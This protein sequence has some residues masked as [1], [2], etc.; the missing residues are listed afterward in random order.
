MCGVVARRGC[1][2]ALRL[3]LRVE[4]VVCRV[5]VVRRL[6]HPLFHRRRSRLRYLLWVLRT[7]WFVLQ[8]LSVKSSSCSSAS[9][10]PTAFFIATNNDW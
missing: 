7:L 4:V 9:W 5:V 1:C 2:Y 3:L 6:A 8:L 10:N